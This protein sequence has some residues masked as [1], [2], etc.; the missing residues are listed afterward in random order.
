L[1]LELSSENSRRTKCHWKIPFPQFHSERESISN[2]QT[3]KQQQQTMSLRFLRA[4]AHRVKTS[5]VHKQQQ[6]R[7]ASGIAGIEVYIPNQYISQAEL[8]QHDQVSTG[9]YTKGLGQ[10]NMAFVNTEREDSV[11]M[12]MSAVHNLLEKYQIDPSQVGR[13]EIGSETPIDKSKSI[14]SNLMEIFGEN[15]DVEGIDNVHACYGGTSAL[16]NSVYWLEANKNIYQ[17]KQQYAIVVCGDVSTYKEKAARPSG[18]AGAVAML[19]SSNDDAPLQIDLSKKASHFEHAY[20][21]YK[22]DPVSPF[23]TVDGHFSNICYL[24]SVDKCYERFLN[25]FTTGKD[26]SN[27]DHAL[28]HA[29]Y[30][31]LVQKSLARLVYNDARLKQ[32]LPAYLNANTESAEKAASL[33]NLT[34]EESYSSKDLEKLFAALAAEVYNK[35]TESSTLLN[36]ELGN[37]YTAS[38]Y[39]GLASLVWNEGKSLNDKSLLLFSYGSGLAATLFNVNAKD[40]AGSQFS[41][42]QIQSA[43]DIKNRLEQR[44]KFSPADYEQILAANT[45]RYLKSDY[46]SATP[47]DLLPQGAYYLNSVDALWRRVYKRK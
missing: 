8:E 21:F 28:F 4:N 17:G 14:K 24:R 39:M 16:L 15:T 27:F 33:L 37:C 43:L 12:I 6:V 29:P 42:K 7:H 30:N 26:L 45:A 35:K 2:K 32:Q 20:D 36:K 47:V 38:L 25:K 40:V 9:K 46:Q 44:Q 22:P 41:L 23:P 34:P 13:L 19:L 1:F 18:G 31:K 3:N 10:S 11:S 5:H